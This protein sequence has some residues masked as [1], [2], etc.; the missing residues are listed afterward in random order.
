MVKQKLSAKVD[1]KTIIHAVD[2]LSPDRA[3]IAVDFLEFL[4]Q[5][6]AEWDATTEL[7]SDK[8]LMSDIATARRDVAKG[9]GLSSWRKTSA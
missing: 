1:R 9:I 4:H 6:D 2:Q 5:K 3:R 7:L 8:K